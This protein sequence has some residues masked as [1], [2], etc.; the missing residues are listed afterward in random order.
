M[1]YSKFSLCTISSSNISLTMSTSDINFSLYLSH[2]SRRGSGENEPANSWRSPFRV[3][4]FYTYT[5]CDELW[6]NFVAWKV[7]FFELLLFRTAFFNDKPR[8]VYLLKVLWG[9]MSPLICTILLRSFTLE[10]D[11]F[12][13]LAWLQFLRARDFFLKF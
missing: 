12:S 7:L 2:S 3:I 5:K 1:S 8:D 4:A 11:F 10:L 13:L 6:R 9:L